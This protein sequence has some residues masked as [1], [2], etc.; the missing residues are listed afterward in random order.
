MLYCLTLWQEVSATVYT[1]VNPWIEGVGS[2]KV[3]HVPACI[4]PFHMAMKCLDQHFYDCHFS[5]RLNMWPPRSPDLN[6]LNMWSIKEDQPAI[7]HS[8]PLLLWT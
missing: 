6:L 1:V 4:P 3:I 8:R 5:Y 7:Q 2:M